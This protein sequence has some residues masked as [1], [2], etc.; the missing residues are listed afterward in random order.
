MSHRTVEQIIGRLLTD[1][2][3]RLE[4]IRAP[5]RTLE[6][7]SEQG[8]ELTRIEVHALTGTDA[9]LWSDAAS[10]IDARLQRCSLKTR[11]GATEW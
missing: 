10:R 5:K 7:L 3:L 9:R 2:E 11:D 6:R 1:E 4:F 8:W